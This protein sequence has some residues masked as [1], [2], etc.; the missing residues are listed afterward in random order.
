MLIKEWIIKDNALYTVKV[1]LKSA[2]IPKILSIKAKNSRL[3]YSILICIH[4]TATC[5]LEDIFCLSLEYLLWTSLT[6]SHCIVWAW[7]STCTVVWIVHVIN[8][9]GNWQM[10]RFLSIYLLFFRNKSFWFYSTLQVKPLF[11]IVDVQVTP[12][13]QEALR[14]GLAALMRES[15]GL[16]AGEAWV[17]TILV[18]QLLEWSEKYLL[19]LTQMIKS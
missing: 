18:V 8:C 5:A 12:E 14:A 17:R 16:T 4:T 1:A 3:C 10:Q 9:H 6:V 7:V 19:S 2:S 13:R 15:T 11:F